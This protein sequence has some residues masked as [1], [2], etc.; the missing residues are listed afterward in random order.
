[1][2]AMLIL[3]FVSF[4]TTPFESIKDKYEKNVPFVHAVIAVLVFLAIPIIIVIGTFVNISSI[5]DSE[6]RAPLWLYCFASFS[7]FVWIPMQIQP[8]FNS[9]ISYY[10]LKTR[11]NTIKASC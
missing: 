8:I 4:T 11:I 9:G 5:N 2:L 6:L 1:M 3:I 10:R 7:I